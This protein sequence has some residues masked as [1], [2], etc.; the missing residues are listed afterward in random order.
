M[1]DNNIEREE[2]Q[3]QE[4]N[5]P[6]Y[7]KEQHNHNCQQFF[8][9]VSS[10]V[11]AMPGANVTQHA[12]QP[13]KDDAGAEEKNTQTTA[14]TEAKHNEGKKRGGRKAEV[15]FADR[16]QEMAALF[17]EFLTR[18]KRYNVDIDSST[19]NYINKAFVM[20]YKNLERPLRLPMQANGNACYRFLKDDCKLSFIAEK[21]TYANFIRGYIS[22]HDRE[23][24]QDIELAVEEFLLDSNMK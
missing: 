6:T 12:Q 13:M 8:A 2:M 21:K 20:F 23:K 24:L 10:C 19:E 7:I 11:F 5:K 3:M 9:P 1:K 4:G 17:V 18:H 15:L 22:T 14:D 16:Q